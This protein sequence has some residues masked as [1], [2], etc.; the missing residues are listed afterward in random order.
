MEVQREISLELNDRRIGSQTKAVI[1]RMED[2]N[3]VGRTE[4]DAPEIDNEVFITAPAGRLAIGQFVDVTITDATEF[5]L[6][7]ELT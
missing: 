7:A 1:E 4:W 2:G 5:D 6:Y 3:Y